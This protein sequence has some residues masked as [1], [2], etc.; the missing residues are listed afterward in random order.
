[1]DHLLDTDGH[2]ENLILGSACELDG[3]GNPT[4]GSATVWVSDLWTEVVPTLQGNRMKL[5]FRVRVDWPSA[6][7]WRATLVHFKAPGGP[8]DVRA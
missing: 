1:M 5:H 4:T 6:L 3:H 2:G 7:K 8:F